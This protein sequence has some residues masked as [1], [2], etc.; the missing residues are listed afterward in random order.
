M[1]DP[2]WVF[3]G[4]LLGMIGSIRYGVTIVRGTVRPNLVTWSLWAA[5][6]LIGFFAQLDSGVGLPAVMTLAAGAGPL[7]VIMTSLVT[8]RHYAHLSIVDLLCAGV[9]VTALAVWLGLDEAPLA[10]FFAVA[11][12]A[13]AA[14][15]T[16]IKAWRHPDSENIFFYT[17]VGTGATITLMTISR[18]APHTW[19]FAVYQVT[20]CVVLVAVIA[21]RRHAVRGAP[22]A[23]A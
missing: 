4:A 9:A 7:I 17:L 19:I 10:V 13:V 11:A 14:L 12:D 15:P 1:L 5:A 22:P 18:W 21:T 20:I 16:L 8:R 6:P 3:V 23:Y 2:H